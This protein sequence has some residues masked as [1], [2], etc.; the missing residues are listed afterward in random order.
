ME[1]RLLE[2]DKGCITL[3]M[4]LIT[5]G[6]HSVTLNLITV[7]MVSSVYKPYLFL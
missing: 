2:I 1:Y 4:Q 7:K 6:M 5:L 3:E